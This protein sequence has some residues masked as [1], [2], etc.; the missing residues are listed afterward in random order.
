MFVASDAI[1]YWVDLSELDQAE[2][3]KVY[4]LI[5]DWSFTGP[6]QEEGYRQYSFTWNEPQSVESVTGLPSSVFR[7]LSGKR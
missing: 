1:W 6:K 5:H 2:F 4:Q 7:R 3:E